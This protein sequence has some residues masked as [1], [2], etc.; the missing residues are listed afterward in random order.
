MRAQ[1]RAAQA[2]LRKVLLGELRSLLLGWYHKLSRELDAAFVEED[3]EVL[4]SNVRHMCTLHSH[5]VLM[6]RNVEADALT[7]ELVTTLVCGMAFL[8]TRHQWNKGL[9]DNWG[10]IVGGA[11]SFDAWRVPETELYECMH[12]LRRKL[13]RWLRESATQKQLDAV[14]TAVVRIS[15]GAGSMVAAKREV[16][17]R[18]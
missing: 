10:H 12:V 14:M 4:D 8:A 5:L 2:G 11:P 7:E 16:A 13:V 9:L 6:T 15:E 3:S 1:L 18:W 17:Q